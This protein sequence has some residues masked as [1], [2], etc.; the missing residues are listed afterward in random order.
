MK[1][2]LEVL[3]NRKISRRK[4]LKDTGKASAFL[5]VSSVLPSEFFNIPF[6][7]K[8][9]ISKIPIFGNILTLNT[10][11]DRGMSKM[12]VKINANIKNSVYKFDYKLTKDSFILGYIAVITLLALL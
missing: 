10:S 7:K 1:S 9:N 2:R 12:D 11:K 5:A 4:M 3:I 8:I 6:L